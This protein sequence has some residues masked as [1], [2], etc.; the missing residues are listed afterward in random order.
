VFKGERSGDPFAVPERLDG[1]DNCTKCHTDHQNI[2]KGACN[3]CHPAGAAAGSGSA[4]LFLQKKPARLDWPAGFHFNHF[5]GSESKGHRS[6]MGKPGER[7]ASGCV[8]CHD[9]ENVKQADAVLDMA[10][11]G[12]HGSLQLCIKCHVNERGWFHWTLPD[13]NSK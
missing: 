8:K 6:Y 12:A 9:F 5:T 7:S 11:P 4:V 2:E 10:I 13:P 3:F 1:V